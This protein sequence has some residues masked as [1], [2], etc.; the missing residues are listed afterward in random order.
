MADNIKK[1]LT[2]TPAMA[3]RIEQLRDEIGVHS[4][5]SV[6]HF[7]VSRLWDAKHPAYAAK[8]ASPDPA[9]RVRIRDEEKKAREEIVEK[10]QIEV[11][12]Q[13]GGQVLEEEGGN[14]VCVYHTY[15]GKKRYEQKIGLRMLSPDL[16]KSQYM[17][18]REKVE[19]L[20]KDGLVDYEV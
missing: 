18:S 3:A 13:L 14:K 16:V 11:C 8:L 7:A 19:Q 5:S 6:I 2:F 17:P 10:E 15:T 20:Q 12:N 4:F 1:M 9:E